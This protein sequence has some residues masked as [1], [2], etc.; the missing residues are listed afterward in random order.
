[1]EGSLHLA[2]RQSRSVANAAC[3]ATDEA[4]TPVTA[5]SMLS[6]P[7]GH[8]NVA[9]KLTHY[10]PPRG[11]IRDLS[12]THNAASQVYP[13]IRQL[14]IADLRTRRAAAKAI[15]MVAFLENWPSGG[16]GLIG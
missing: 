11:A 7:P 16:P 10:R 8:S 15:F 13:R 6:R 9:S 4:V 1:M 2:L 12:H 5:A 3:E 14:R